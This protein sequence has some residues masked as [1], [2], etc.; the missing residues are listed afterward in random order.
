MRLASRLA[1]TMAMN[2]PTNEAVV[3]RVLGHGESSKPLSLCLFG[4]APDTSNL[5]VSA[6]CYSVLGG[7]ARIEPSIRVTVFD[8]GRAIRHETAAFSNGPFRFAR[9]GASQTRRYYRPESYWHIRVCSWLGGLGNPAAEALL[10]CDAVLDIS[11]GDSFTDLYGP[12]RFASVTMSKLLALEV[13]K[14][15]ILLPQTYGPF[16]DRKKR[17]IASEI[18]RRAA[19]AWARDPRSYEV[20]KELAGP[21]FD[22]QRHRSGV[23]VAFAL[24]PREPRVPLPEPLHTWLAE[25]YHGQV[26]G[27]NVS[28]LIWNDPQGARS[29]YGL[30]ADYRA[31]VLGFLRRLFLETDTR[32]VLVPH[33]VTPAG[34]YESDPAANQAVL[35]ALADLPEARGRLAVVSPQYDESEMKWIIA[36]CGWF[37]GTRMH[38][39]IAALSSGVLAVAIAYSVKTQGV[40]ETC[41]CGDC[42]VDPRTISTPQ[43]VESLW[44]KWRVA[45][46]AGSDTRRT[47]QVNTMSAEQQIGEILRAAAAR[48]RQIQG[49]VA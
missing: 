42:V 40:F 16:R 44:A 9:C 48:G 39:C 21:E 13:E 4:A 33:V 18:V 5:G 14:P 12:R 22:P 43:V 30:K 36:R 26:I 25:D 49:V 38:A 31:S 17:R 35:A 34:H 15:L 47:E 28:G 3:R 8:Q 10:G 29:R 1:K 37:C 19:Q 41:G 27:F 11:G 46:T 6:L 32:V 2:T 20:L 7:L 23:D 24:E 45:G